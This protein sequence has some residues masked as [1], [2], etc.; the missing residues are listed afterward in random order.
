MDW[1]KWKR[2]ARATGPAK[3]AEA[4]ASPAQAAAE[5]EASLEGLCD[6]ALE[7]AARIFGEQDAP[8]PPEI[9]PLC[10][11]VAEALRSELARRKLDRGAPRVIVFGPET[12]PLERLRF[13]A[14]LTGVVRF[15]GKALPALVAE[16][17][18]L[19]AAIIDVDVL[20]LATRL[21][22]AALAGV[23]AELVKG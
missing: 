15:L 10:A 7:L 9:A 1:K 19:K 3:P 17:G 2:R 14:F 21:R 8:N 4:P 22:A 18:R 23:P 5:R 11:E 13:A 20:A 12:A 6:A 16:H